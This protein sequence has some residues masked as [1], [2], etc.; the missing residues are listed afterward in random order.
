M[1]PQVRKARLQ[2]S[3]SHAESRA[4]ACSWR[5]VAASRLKVLFAALLKLGSVF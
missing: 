2:L 4:R 3:C 5:C 1:R